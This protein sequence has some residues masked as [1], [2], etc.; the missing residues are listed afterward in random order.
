M[1][2]PYRR[3]RAGHFPRR[4]AVLILGRVQSE[5][6]VEQRPSLLSGVGIMLG[7]ALSNQVGAALGAHAFG[8]VGPAGV[9]AVRQVVAAVVLMPV[10]RPPLRR[11]SWSQWWPVLLLAVVFGCMN[12]ALYTAIDRLGLGLAVTLEF[13]GPLGVALA[14]SRSR[15]DLL[16]AVAAAAGVY[17]L[18]LPGP[19][20]DWL[21]LGIGVLGGVSWA[22]YIVLNRT[23]GRRLPGLQAPAVAALLC[24]VAYFP[25]VLLLLAQDRFTPAA[26]G[27]A[28]VAGVLSSVV[29]YAAD[30][31]ALRFV[32][33]RFFG[34]FMSVHPVLAALVGIAL[35][36]Q[37]LG[38]H[39][40]IGIGV[41]VLT[42]AAAVAGSRRSGPPARTSTVPATEE[43]DPTARTGTAPSPGSAN[44]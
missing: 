27:F 8:A 7:S 20:S 16:L 44:G 10:A 23:A 14:G 39:E 15:R 1:R 40:W 31:T 21:G 34:V 19:S 22:A 4:R 30:L 24:A 38:A 29:P 42:N 18:V 5:P 11:M 36:G 26:L 37:H 43:A 17:V 6:V 9:V 2:R 35:L 25:V 41:V 3:V 13:L 33:A 28:V 32:P 12:L